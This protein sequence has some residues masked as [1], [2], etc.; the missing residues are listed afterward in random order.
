MDKKKKILEVAYALFSEKGYSLSMSEISQAVDIKTPSLYSHFKSKDEILELTIK[1]EI[2]RCFD[3]VFARTLEL[4]NKSCEEELRSLFFLAIE[5]YND[6]SRLKFW[7]HISLLQHEHLKNISKQLIKK[8]NISVI[9]NIKSCFE[10]GIKNKEIRADITD[11]AIYLY[12][13]MIQ[14][15]L[16]VI[17]FDIIDKTTE[18]QAAM[19]WESYWNG[20]KFQG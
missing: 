9:N 3:T 11:G 17:E 6:N 5:Y 1:S 15:F 19:V 10:K 20:I 16:E 4:A 18:D 8:R 14:G 2:E 12:L 13:S 7:Y